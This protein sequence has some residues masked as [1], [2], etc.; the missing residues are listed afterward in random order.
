LSVYFSF[1]VEFG[2]KRPFPTTLKKES[3]TARCRFATIRFF[4]TVFWENGR[5][6][7]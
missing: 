2:A 3:G 1:V 7:K 4:C 5:S 6:A